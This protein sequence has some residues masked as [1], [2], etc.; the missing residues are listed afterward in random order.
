MKDKVFLGRIKVI[1]TRYG[2]M[3]KVSFGPKDL[4][5][6]NEHKNEQGWS[7]WVLKDSQSG[8]KYM[9]LDDWKAAR[10]TWQEG[11][12]EDDDDEDHLLV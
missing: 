7:N 10:E 4:E 9:E 8:A 1:T 2:E 3:I 5:I 6:L 11:Q 12:N